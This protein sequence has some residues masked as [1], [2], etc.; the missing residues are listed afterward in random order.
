[1]MNGWPETDESKKML[2]DQIRAFALNKIVPVAKKH[3]ET[4]EFPT[5]I[6]RQ[7]VKWASWE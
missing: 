6:I 5:D 4:G 1:M 7:L 3:D 2:L